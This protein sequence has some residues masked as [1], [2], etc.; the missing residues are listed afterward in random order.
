MTTVVARDR[1]W[2]AGN[3]G[4]SLTL[5][6][7]MLLGNGVTGAG[8]CRSQVRVQTRRRQLSGQSRIRVLTGSNSAE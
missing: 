5:W 4:M 7:R 6:K 2:Q 1:L 3:G 8:V